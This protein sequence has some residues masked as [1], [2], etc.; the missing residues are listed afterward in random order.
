MNIKISFLI[1]LSLLCIKPSWSGAQ[2]VSLNTPIL[3]DYLRRQQLL[4]N[5]D[6]THSFLIRPIY[7]AKAFGKENGIDVDGSF[8]DIDESETSF[9]TEDGKG[10]FQALPVIIRTQYN[11]NVAFGVNNGAMIANKGLQFILSG[12]IYF[13]Y[14]KWSLQFQP[15]IIT[16]QNNDF[17]GFPIEHDGSTWIEYYEWLNHS[18]IPER[19]GTGSYTKLLS[20]QSSIRFNAGNVSMGISTENIWWGPGR[21]NALIM[22]NNA[23]GFLH[24]TINTQKPIKTGIGSFE[25]QLIAGRLQNSG[26]KPPH[27]DYAY[28][29]TPLYVPKRDKDWRYLAG[30]IL[31]YQPKWVPGFSIGYS[32]VSQMYHNDMRSFADYLPV[33]NGGKKRESIL[34]TDVAKRNQL[35][36]G[37]FRWMDPRGHLEFYAEYGSNGNSRTISDFLTNPDLTRA[38]TLGFTNL[39]SLKNPQQ[40]IQL[41][42]EITQTGQTVRETIFDKNSWYTHSHVRHGYTHMGQVLGAGNGPGSNVIFLEAGWVKDFNKIGFQ[43]ERIVYNNDFYYKRFEDIKDWR[44]KFVDIVPSLVA[45]WR[46]KNFLVSSRIQYAHSFNYKWYII[47]IPDQYWVP[48][49][50]KN[51]L[52]ANVGFAYVFE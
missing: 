21:R 26:F 29:Q 47:N 28:R 27:S 36:S 6:S 12:G 4:G 46:F 14:G 10:R 40:F 15:E 17:Q 37:F 9:I 33:F 42:G 38:F 39:I 49:F 35:S 8:T 32:S 16:A 5:L 45:D 50:D 25:G 43:I 22:S 20:G 52:V 13:E 44:V 34:N 30:L 23:P 18:D 48:G 2:S 51:N 41:G 31:A 3:E 1:F 7:P 19:F 11:S 24:A